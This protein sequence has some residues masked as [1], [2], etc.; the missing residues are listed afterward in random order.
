MALL[1][2]GYA[3]QKGFGANLVNVPDPSKRIREQ[4]LQALRGMEEELRWNNKQAA[5]LSNT[6]EKNAALEAQNRA[7][8]FRLSQTISTTMAEAK[9]RNM[10]ALARQAERNQAAKQS[11][12]KA[13]AQLTKTGFAL[14]KKYDAKRKEDADIFAHQVWNEHGIGWGKLQALQTATDDVWQDS[15]QSPPVCNYS[16]PLVPEKRHA[17]L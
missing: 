13:L 2:K 11:D 7:D 17:R 16:V 10:D 4:G 9:F 6:L 15:A 12:I 3:Q 14:W 5:R 1:Y 8:N